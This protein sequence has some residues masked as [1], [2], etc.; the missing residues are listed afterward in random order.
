MNNWNVDVAHSHVGFSVRHMMVTNVRGD[1][2]GI[3]GNLQGD[4]KNLTEANI[5]FTIDT[6]TINTNNED[7][8]NHLRSADFFDVENYPKI[9]FKSTDIKQVGEDEYDVKGDLTIKDTTKTTTFKVTRTG[10][11]KNPWGVEVVGFEGEG[12]I[13]REDFGLTW[14]QALETGGVLV[15]DE[16]KITIELQ[17]NPA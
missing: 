9:T 2:T 12:K 4:P 14:N 10:S 17:V 6:N 8:D 7:R 11:G 1:F 3:E 13:S 5:E 15:G 16:I